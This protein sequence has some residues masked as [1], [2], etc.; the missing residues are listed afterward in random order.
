MK[1]VNS[2]LEHKSIKF[3]VQNE[4]YQPKFKNFQ[5]KFNLEIN[6]NS[7]LQSD[8]NFKLDKIDYL[9]LDYLKIVI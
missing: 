7:Q 6:I 9:K 4:L 8:F 1:I 2:T 3:K 5:S